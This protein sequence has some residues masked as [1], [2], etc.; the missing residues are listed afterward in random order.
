[1]SAEERSVL[2]DLLAANPTSGVALGGYLYKIRF[3]RGDSGKSGGVRIIYLFAGENLP[4][5]LLAV[6][7]KNERANLSKAELTAL[8]A[9]AASLI[10]T[11]EKDQP[12]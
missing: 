5:F 3:G 9:L 1:M 11:Y 6:F 2:I 10:K 7:A 4:I 8:A 12:L